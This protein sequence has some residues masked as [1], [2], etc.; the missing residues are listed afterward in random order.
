[1]T[2]I[3]WHSSLGLCPYQVPTPPKPQAA[4]IRPALPSSWL[5]SPFL[6]SHLSHRPANFDPWPLHSNNTSILVLAVL[7]GADGALEF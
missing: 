4:V 5:L 3:S 2:V 6:G 1:M 7:C